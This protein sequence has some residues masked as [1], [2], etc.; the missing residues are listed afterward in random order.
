MANDAVV[1]GRYGFAL[2]FV[3]HVNSVVAVCALDGAL[4]DAIDDEPL[5]AT[6]YFA[7]LALN[8]LLY[9]ILWGSDPGYVLPERSPG[10]IEVPTT[11]SETSGLLSSPR[12]SMEA[13]ARTTQLAMNAR[14][15]VRAASI[16]KDDTGVD[17]ALKKCAKC[18]MLQPMR[19]KHCRDCEHCIY[20]FDH[21]CFWLGTCVG[22]KN[23]RI[24]YLFIFSESMLCVLSTYLVYTTF[25]DEDKVEDWVTTNFYSLL[26]FSLNCMFSILPTVLLGYH[27]FLMSTNQTTWE[28]VSPD[29]ITYLQDLPSHYL[30]FDQGFWGNLKYFWLDLSDLPRYTLDLSPAYEADVLC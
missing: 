11:N 22:R 26:T 28:N 30:P 15:T 27:T 6:A 23:H 4:R 16:S 29:T 10:E 25:Q 18:N 20:R 19:V 7:F 24:F 3:L 12:D 2:W 13:V 5:G 17:V 21:H 8:T 9:Y 1:A 14:P